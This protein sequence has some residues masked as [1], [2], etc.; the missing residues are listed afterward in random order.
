MSLNVLTNWRNYNG[1]FISN[2]I[3]R[4]YFQPSRG[5]LSINS[6]QTFKTSETN[7]VALIRVI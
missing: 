1:I 5:G 4:F 6:S 2:R 7:G 3:Y